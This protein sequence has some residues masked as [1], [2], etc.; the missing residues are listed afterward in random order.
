MNTIV[1]REKPLMPQKSRAL[2]KLLELDF[3]ILHESEAIDS[4][5]GLTVINI[6][7]KC[8]FCQSEF[9]AERDKGSPVQDIVPSNCPECDFPRNIHNVLKSFRKTRAGR[10]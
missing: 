5:R 2:N 8:P 4:R 7:M 9:M 1:K 6:R 10:S 3:E